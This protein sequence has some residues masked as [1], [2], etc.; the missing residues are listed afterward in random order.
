MILRVMG[1]LMSIFGCVYT[2]WWVIRTESQPS[3]YT[4]PYIEIVSEYFDRRAFEDPPRDEYDR[5]IKQTWETHFGGILETYAH[6]VYSSTA[7]A[8]FLGA[9][10]Q[11]SGAFFIIIGLRV[12]RKKGVLVESAECDQQEEA[13]T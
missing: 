11:L 4:E 12:D 8:A 9:F 7:T 1:L 3:Y 6:K 2:C 5:K 10:T 13:V